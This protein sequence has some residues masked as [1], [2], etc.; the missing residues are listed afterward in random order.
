VAEVATPS[1]EKDMTIIRRQKDPRTAAQRRADERLLARFERGEALAAAAKAVAAA[2][3]RIRA[4]NQERRREVARLGSGIAELRRTFG[5]TQEDIARAIGTSKPN[6]CALERGRA[7]GI[8]LERFLAV[9]ETLGAQTTTAFPA[10]RGNSP[11]G[12]AF[13]PTV[14]IRSLEDS[15]EAA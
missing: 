8:F 2:A 13:A 3:R 4:R 5:L 9:L 7:P 14:A 15:V 12:M 6:I 1:E 11:K 10:E